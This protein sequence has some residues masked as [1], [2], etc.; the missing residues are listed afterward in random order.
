MTSDSRRMKVD[1]GGA[2]RKTRAEKRRR[3]SKGEKRAVLS[4][5]SLSLPHNKPEAGMGGKQACKPSNSRRH[6]MQT[7]TET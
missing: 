1:R 3:G 6:R 5:Q 4:S 2:K 7:D